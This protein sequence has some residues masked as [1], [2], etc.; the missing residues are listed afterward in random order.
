[1]FLYFSLKGNPLSKRVLY[2]SCMMCIYV[3]EWRGG[4]NIC[5]AGCIPSFFGWNKRKDWWFLR[6][7]SPYLVNHIYRCLFCIMFFCVL[8]LCL[9]YFIALWSS[10]LTGH[11]VLS[12]GVKIDLESVEAI[13]TISPPRHKKALHYFFGKNIFL[14]RFIPNFTKLTKH[15]TKILK[16]EGEVKRDEGSM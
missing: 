5:I 10:L 11:I 1:M 7:C 3:R 16:K 14:K 2:Y 12:Q 6:G 15:M 13:N 4:C 8:F 9:F